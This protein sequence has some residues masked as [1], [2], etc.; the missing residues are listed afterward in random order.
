[1]DV[2]TAFLHSELEESIFIEIPKGL[3]TN[4]SSTTT[5]G[6]RMVSRLIKLIYGLKQAPR[7]WY[8]KINKLFLDHGFQRSKEDH[9]VYVS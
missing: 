9:S 4:I 5:N 2:K 3:H 1:M 7:A 8:V 6:Q